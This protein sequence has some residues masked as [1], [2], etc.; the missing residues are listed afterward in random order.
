[1]KKKN[2]IKN[3]QAAKLLIESSSTVRRVQIFVHNETV[4]RGAGAGAG[5]IRD[6][7]NLYTGRRHTVSSH[8]LTSCVSFKVC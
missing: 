3:K 2:K 5:E 7:Y 8:D 6:I 4:V 1:M